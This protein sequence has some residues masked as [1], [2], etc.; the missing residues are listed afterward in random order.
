MLNLEFLLNKIDEVNHMAIECNQK[1]RLLGG[2]GKRCQN[3]IYY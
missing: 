3:L 2:K 1:G